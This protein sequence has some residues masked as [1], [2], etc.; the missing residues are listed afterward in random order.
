VPEPQQH[1]DERLFSLLDSYVERLNR[2]DRPDPRLWLDAHPQLAAALKCLDA[3]EAFVPPPRGPAPQAAVPTPGGI[4]A[5]FLAQTVALDGHGSP[6]A[7]SSFVAAMPLGEFGEYELLAEIGRGGMGVVYRARQTSLDRVVALKMILASHLASED[8]VRRFQAEARAAAAVSHPHVVRVFEVGQIHAQHYFTMELVAGESLA[9]RLAG[10][11]D[12]GARREPL[13]V[14]EGARLLTAVARA[15]EYLHRRG[16]VHRDLKPSNVLVDE[17]GRPFV[18]DFGL[19]KMFIADSRSTATGMIAGTPSYMAPEQAAGRNADVG[20]LSDVYSLGAMLYELLTGR[21]PFR[22]ENPLDTLLQVLEREPAWPREINAAVPR[23]LELICMKCLEKS[24]QDRYSSAAEVADELERYL[25]GE[26]LLV[27]PPGRMQRLWRWA[28]REAP[29][30]T[31]LA[32]LGIFYSVE[33]VHYHLLRGV[34]RKFHATVTAIMLLWIAGSVVFQ[35]LIKQPAWESLARYAWAALDVVL[36]TATLYAASGAASATV[37]GYPV[38][39]VLSG[40]WLER[41]LVWFMTGISAA[42]YLFLV[43]DFYVLRPELQL[44]FDTAATRHFY[45]LAALV[46][47]GFAMSYQVTRMRALSRYYERWRLT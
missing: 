35:R 14:D 29:L 16:I 12:R 25:T 40:L 3:L 41:R 44:Q 21:P 8:Q 17:E 24:P 39:V 47:V 23:P 45:F 42:A 46:T 27:R 9:A 4:T 32:A 43:W 5:G 31:R 19:A 11:T 28:Q 15:V 33:L 18:T 10:G 20:P 1:D 30:S 37:I 22:E 6:V 36:L 13:T 26:D 38:L 34:D 2:G 7:T